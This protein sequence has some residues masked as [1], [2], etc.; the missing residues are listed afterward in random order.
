MSGGDGSGSDFFEKGE[1]NSRTLFGIDMQYYYPVIY[2]HP[3][4][5]KMDISLVR[6]F[7]Q[8]LVVPDRIVLD[9]YFCA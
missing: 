3:D 2:R 4:T 7:G 5:S 9:S 1:R 6:A 8:H